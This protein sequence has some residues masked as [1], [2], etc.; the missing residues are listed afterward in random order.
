MLCK[1]TRDAGSIPAASTINYLNNNEFARQQ[2]VS[3]R[4]Q[5]RSLWHDLGTVIDARPFPL[6]PSFVA[7]HIEMAP[8][9]RAA[10]IT[11]TERGML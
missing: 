9:S 10:T 4:P 2:T 3:N 1:S 5:P 8:Y 6:A 7:D 11:T